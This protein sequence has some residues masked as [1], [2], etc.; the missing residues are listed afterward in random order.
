MAMTRRPRIVPQIHPKVPI[1]DDGIRV[2]HVGNRD[3]LAKAEALA[4]RGIEQTSGE[5]AEA[6]YDGLVA[7]IKDGKVKGLVVLGDSLDHDEELMA[8]L[9]GLDFLIVMDNRLSETAKQA[10]VILLNTCSIRDKAENQL[11]SDLGKL[12]EWKVARPGRVI[13]V[14]GL[15]LLPAQRAAD[16]AR[17]TRSGEQ[18]MSMWRTPR[19]ASASTTAF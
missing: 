9:E 6:T 4:K 7:A 8:A 1:T 17:H 10:D 16:A 11:Y 15:S 12:K 18:G 13:G 19:W 14:G 5:I 2:I 3:H